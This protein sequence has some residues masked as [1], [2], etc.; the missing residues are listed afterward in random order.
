[1]AARKILTLI[2]QV[3][4]V[5]LALFFISLSTFKIV[6]IKENDNTPLQIQITYNY[7]C[8]FPSIHAIFCDN[9]YM[10]NYWRSTSCPVEH[11][12]N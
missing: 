9:A 6:E 12:K 11:A 5:R 3:V 8:L 10:A 4:V 7:Y 2:A 1:M